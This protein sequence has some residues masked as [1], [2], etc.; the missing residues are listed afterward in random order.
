MDGHPQAFGELVDRYQKVIFNAVLRIVNNYED[1]KDTTQTVFVKAFEN[2]SS[3]DSRYKFFSWI[4][5]LAVNEALNEVNR[6]RQTQPLNEDIRCKDCTPEEILHQ[7]Q[8][9]EQIDEALAGLSS[10]YR[11]V[12]VMKYFLE[13]S[14]REIA[15]I[16]H[17]EEK[18][19]KSRLYTAR[20]HLCEALTKRGITARGN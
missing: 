15:E 9:D 12:I 3:Y 7:H 2:L 5:R 1:A 8:L 11:L 17:V 13:M 14:L 6:R 16:I 18:T 4:Y 19:V 10:D 20:Q